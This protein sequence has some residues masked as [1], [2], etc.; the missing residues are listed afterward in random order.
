MRLT[1]IVGKRSNLSR[2]LNIKIKDSILVSSDEIEKNIENI[3]KYCDGYKNINIIYNS[4]QSSDMLNDNSDFD[5]SLL[6]LF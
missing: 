2:Q 4:F 3:L 5:S 6:N 1:L